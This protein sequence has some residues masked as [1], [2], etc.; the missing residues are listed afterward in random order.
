MESSAVKKGIMIM[1]I[2]FAA[3][4]LLSA[5]GSWYIANYGNEIPI[6]VIQNPNIEISVERID[7]AS[8]S[9]DSGVPFYLT[10]ADVKYK[11][12]W[13]GSRQIAK[14]TLH[15]NTGNIRLDISAEH[16]K[17]EGSAVTVPYIL[18]FETGSNVIAVDSG[19]PYYGYPFASNAANQEINISEAE[20]YFKLASSVDIS[21]DKYP[22]GNYSAN[23]TITVTAEEM[24]SET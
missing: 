14:W 8:F 22:S 17:C 20:I 16:L 23:V 13:D 15:S 7:S 2:S 1:L 10:G 19:N 5:A 18:G 6:T 4:F 24:A 11:D 3:V 9:D 12:G 21:S